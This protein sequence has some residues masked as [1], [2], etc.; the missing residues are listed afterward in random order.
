MMIHGLANFKHFVSN[1]YTELLETPAVV[2]DA[3]LQID[4]RRANAVST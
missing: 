3:G 4:V 1:F 2:A